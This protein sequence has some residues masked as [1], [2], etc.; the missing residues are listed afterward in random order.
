MK[1]TSLRRPRW[2]R[3]GSKVRFAP[4]APQLLDE[5]CRRIA[6][7]A[8][9]A[10]R[11]RVDVVY[12]EPQPGGYAHAP[13]GDRAWQLADCESTAWCVVDAASQ[14]ALLEA[15]LG[16]PGAS[17]PSLIERSIAAETV[18]RL[19]ADDGV[20]GSQPVECA[21]ARPPSSGWWRCNVDLA[22]RSGRTAALQLFCAPSSVDRSRSVPAV[23]DAAP[24][25]NAVP[26]S[27]SAELTAV[28]V[29]LAVI[30]AWTPGALVSLPA[31]ALG[32]VALAASAHVRLARGSLGSTSRES[33]RF[34]AV[35]IAGI[36][37]GR[38]A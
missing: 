25:L 1:R 37:H 33:G 19:I 34:R 27:I 23:P 14:A 21:N 29:P 35:A 7:R 32:A 3:A 38:A 28:A 20:R 17:T 12:T 31:G 15:V 36:P 18:Q 26:I 9:H 24:D 6:D 8:P 5:L 11:R 13:D 30:V 16:G 2:P 22:P 10:L 4:S